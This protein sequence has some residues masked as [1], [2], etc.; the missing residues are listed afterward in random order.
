MTEET[1]A[2]VRAL[3]TPQLREV[4]LARAVEALVPDEAAPI[5]LLPT[6]KQ[7]APFQLKMKRSVLNG[8]F[9]LTPRECRPSSGQFE[10][11][12]RLLISDCF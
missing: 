7:L 10:G 9:S 12:C 8:A 1:L 4:L 3:L 6:M 11:I 5:D 2:D